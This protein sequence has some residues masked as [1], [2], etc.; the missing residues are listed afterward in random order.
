MKILQINALIN[1]GSTGVIARDIG[2][3]LNINGHDVFYASP[4]ATNIDNFYQIG[5][6]LDHK[7]H[8]VLC[9]IFGLQGY[10]S[11]FA[12]LRFIGWIKKLHPD[13]IQIHN[14]HSNYINFKILFSYINKNRIRTIITLHD[15]WFFTGKCFHY[16]YNNCEK[17]M[18]S[19]GN[20]P[21]LHEEQNSLFFDRT[22][23]VLLDKKHFIGQND[24]VEFVAVSEWIAEQASKSIIKDR[25]ITVI[26]NGINL[27]IF[28]PC[29]TFSSFFDKYKEKF[30]VLG[31]ANKW[32]HEENVDTFHYLAENLLDDEMILLVG[33]TEKQKRS[34]PDN[35]IGVS[36]ID[37]K[38]LAQIYSRAD[39]FVNL[40]R[41]DTYPTVNMEALACGTPVITFDS[42]GS[43]ECIIPGKTGYVVKFGDKEAILDSI[44]QIRKNGKKNYSA[45]CRKYAIAN[46]DRNTCYY[47]YIKLYET[48]EVK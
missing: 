35:V 28:Y 31:M 20:C 27:E 32:L 38:F 6:K 1:H 11:I 47:E 30:V 3:Q 41:I 39:V 44:H 25:K 23:K 29:H 13:I 24:S 26:H 40:T 43:K 22:K 18:D 7:L 14:L 15:C 33:C 5:N 17:W 46:F 36:F 16:L 12:T 8:A 34:L 9:R 42:G 19:C 48:S 45:L 37:S 10:F 21:R 2:R 4:E